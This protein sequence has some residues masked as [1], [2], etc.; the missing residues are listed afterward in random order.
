[1]PE[2]HL[3][4]LERKVFE[5]SRHFAREVLR[6]FAAE[7]DRTCDIPAALLAKPEVVNF[8]KVYIPLE[9]GG[10][11]RPRNG[12]DVY[13]LANSARLRLILNEAGG[14]GDASLFIAMPG[15]AL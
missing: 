10:G 1:M 8:M 2:F 12:G 6:P 9:L 15:P 7:A 5:E 3:N 4:E 14:Y 13:D 11:W